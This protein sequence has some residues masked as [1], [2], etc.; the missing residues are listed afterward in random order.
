MESKHDLVNALVY[1]LADRVDMPIGEL[2]AAIEISMFDYDVKKVETT[3]LS[4]GSG[5]ATNELWWYFEM[6]K[7][8]QNLSQASLNQ[9][10]L[11]AYQLVNMVNKE[12]NM[13]TADDIKVFLLKMKMVHGN[14]D[15][16]INNKR[17]VL[18]SI[19]TYL[20]KYDK[21]ARNPM[22]KV[23]PIKCRSQLKKPLT[24]IEIEIILM[25]CDDLPPMARNRALAM[26]YFMLDTGVRVSELCGLK[27]G[28]IDFEHR[29]GIV[30]G[31]GNKER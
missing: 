2:K 14:S 26:V 20:Y 6:G 3:E 25:A 8:S 12:L 1:R 15:I 21:I 28:D 30:L 27:V 18:S 29:K 9:Y 16:T 10:K 5:Q 11:V 17:L 23:D 19:F 22:N 24:E 4:V 7:L 13:I 31:K